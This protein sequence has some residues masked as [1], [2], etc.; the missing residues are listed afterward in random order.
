VNQ[1]SERF[2]Y[3]YLHGFGSDAQSTKG[4]AMKQWMAT[5]GLNLELLDV[6][7]PS[8]ETQTYS[9]ILAHL[10]E[11]DRSTPDGTR[12]RLG[13]SSMGGYLAARWAELNPDRVERL[14]LLCPG[15]DLS[16]R[17]PLL[18]G[19][20]AFAQWEKDGT[21]QVE[22]APGPSR[23]LHWKFV[24]DSREHPAFPEVQC[25][26]RIVHGTRDEVVPIRLSRDYAAGRSHVDL[27]EV[28]DDHV[29]IGSVLRI[30]SAL[31]DFL[32]G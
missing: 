3:A 31:H 19:T 13:G 12:L 21:L 29:L 32:K 7:V 17:W 24:L 20:D 10:D 28:D 6:N 2:R 9:D 25:P 23:P 30:G 22:N 27:I 26:T 16:T 18:V 1:S 14:F 15:F 11:F 5:Q 4:V 8:F